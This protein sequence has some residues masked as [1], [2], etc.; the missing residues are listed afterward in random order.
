MRTTPRDPYRYPTVVQAMGSPRAVPMVYTNP[1]LDAIGRTCGGNLSRGTSI[2][3]PSF[4]TPVPT[5]AVGPPAMERD[6]WPTNPPREHG[7]P[8]CFCTRPCPGFRLTTWPYPSN[9]PTVNQKPSEHPNPR[10]YKNPRRPP[11]AAFSSAFVCGRPLPPFAHR[12][13]ATPT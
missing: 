4:W 2:L 9:R 7:R 6:A 5:Q 10:R 12:E 8:L 11:F 1:S 13:H 3:G